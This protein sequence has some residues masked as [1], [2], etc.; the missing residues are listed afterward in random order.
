V[1]RLAEQAAIDR[2]GLGQAGQRGVGQRQLDLALGLVGGE[3]GRARELLERLLPAVRA[4][5]GQGEIA[6][7]VGI[8]RPCRDRVAQSGELS[9]VDTTARPRE[10][11]SG[12]ARAAVLWLRPLDAGLEAGVRDRAS[13][14]VRRAGAVS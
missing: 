2:L 8:A 7:R 14:G 10:R 1:A 9:L 4:A 5:E 11:R 3:G 13:W 6:A 12:I